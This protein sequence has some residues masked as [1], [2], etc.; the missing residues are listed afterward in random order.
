M[1]IVG[2][3]T[4]FDRPIVNSRDEPLCG[5]SDANASGRALRQKL[6]RLHCIF[7]DSNLCHVANLLK[8]GMMQIVLAMLE[9]ERIDPMLIVEDPLRAL[10]SFGHDTTLQARVPM[11]S[12]RRFSA[13]ELQ[14]L[15]LERAQDLHQRGDLEEVVPRAGEILSL[16]DKTLRELH[17]GNLDALAGRL[18][19]VLKLRILQEVLAQRPRLTWQSPEIKQL[20]HMYSS[21]D[22]DGLYWAYEDAGLV[23]RVVTA[24]EIE[25]LTH[26]PP[27]DTRAYT[28][29]MLLRLAGIDRL[30]RIDWDSIRF[31]L[32]GPNGWPR[33]RSLDLSDPR[34]MTE[35][36]M[37]HLFHEDRMLEEVLDAL[38][39]MGPE[40][41]SRN[42]CLSKSVSSQEAAETRLLPAPETTVVDYR[43]DGRVAEAVTTV[44]QEPNHDG[45]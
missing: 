7:Y 40:E 5:S 36:D 29:A 11:A 41:L 35:N 32:P 17:A 34:E 8:C 3:Q 19:W 12:G 15:F 25:Q 16:C 27:K 10:R 21:L 23:D 22:A 28:R 31:R 45:E 39:D 43:A 14:L 24:G 38:M 4:T 9:M 1:T 33:F 20:D 42:H 37:G 26:E 2:S 44:P 6:A 18:D 13:V 30:G